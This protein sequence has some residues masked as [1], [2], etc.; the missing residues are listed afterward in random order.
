MSTT[1]FK[2][3]DTVD[4]ALDAPG[5]GAGRSVA[6]TLRCIILNA[7]SEYDLMIHPAEDHGEVDWVLSEC[8]LTL[9]GLREGP[10][11]VLRNCQHEQLSLVRMGAS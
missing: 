9:E 3:G 8:D 5:S 2:P 10:V 1:T 11:Y 6:G 4:L 7:G